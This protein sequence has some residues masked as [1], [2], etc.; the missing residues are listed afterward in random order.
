MPQPTYL[1]A[2]WTVPLSVRADPEDPLLWARVLAGWRLGP[3]QDPT[4]GDR[5]LTPEVERALA[6]VVNRDRDEVRSGLLA[7]AT[8]P[9]SSERLPALVNTL[10]GGR[11]V[12]LRIFGAHLTEVQARAEAVVSQMLRE[13]AFAVTPGTRVT[14]AISVDGVRV[15]LTSGRV[16]SGRGGV[17]H[18]FYRS[19][20]AALNVTLA[21]LALTLLVV[22]AVTPAAPYTPLGKAYG[23]AERILSAVLLNVLLLASQFLYFA[24]HRA[25]IEWERP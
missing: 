22:L 16:R 23:L 6:L 25:V 10:D 3:V 18:D 20:Q 5:R 17:A 7:Y 12:T 8:W 4:S 13:D 19:N 9:H 21:V 14:L 2:I 15:D 11:F 24:R 1:R